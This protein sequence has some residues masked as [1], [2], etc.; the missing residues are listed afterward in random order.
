[1]YKNVQKLASE[2]LHPKYWCRQK[3]KASSFKAMNLSALSNYFK[4][5]VK[6]NTKN[7]NAD[8]Q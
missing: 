7:Q 2:L 5:T 1:M 8:I 6:F 4:I 3:S